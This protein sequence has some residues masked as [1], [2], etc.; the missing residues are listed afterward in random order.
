MYGESW[1]EGRW[2]S[3]FD[4]AP[5]SFD[6]SEEGGMFSF[7]VDDETD[8]FVSVEEKDFWTSTREVSKDVANVVG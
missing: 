3:C 2:V 6:G 8:V 5:G 4:D 1:R 7:P